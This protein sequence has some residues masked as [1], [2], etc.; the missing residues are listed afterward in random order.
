[1]ESLYD[2]TNISCGVLADK[3]FNETEL[4]DRK[5]FNLTTHNR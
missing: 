1:M 3:L 5:I 4:H 2:P